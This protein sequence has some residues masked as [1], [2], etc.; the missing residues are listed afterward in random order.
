M[1]TF[2]EKAQIKICLINKHFNEYL[3]TNFT[4]D[5]INVIELKL[6]DEQYGPH[7][8]W[9]DGG[10]DE[11]SDK[12]FAWTLWK[13]VEN[14]YKDEQRPCKVREISASKYQ[15]LDAIGISLGLWKKEDLF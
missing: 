1:K 12:S 13:I 7:Y 5:D 11:N 9:E 3:D 10:K 2:Q 14:S 4:L 15:R 8:A 6:T